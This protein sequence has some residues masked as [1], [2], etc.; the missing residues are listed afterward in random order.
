MIPA[1]WSRWKARRREEALASEFAADLLAGHGR[2]GV[3]EELRRMASA[4][5]WWGDETREQLVLKA[6]RRAGAKVSSSDTSRAIFRD[7]DGSPSR[8]CL[9]AM[10]LAALL[11]GVILFAG[12]MLSS[13]VSSLRH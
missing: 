4:G 3:G 6:L 5:E 13:L 2:E 1:L 10:V 7:E 11:W 12:P 9:L 8:G